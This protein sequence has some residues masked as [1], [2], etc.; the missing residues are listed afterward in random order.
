M[1]DISDEIPIDIIKYSIGGDFSCHFFTINL[2]NK[3]LF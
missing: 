1:A 3:P 2:F